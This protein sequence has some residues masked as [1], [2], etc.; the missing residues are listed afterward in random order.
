[1]KHVI[2]NV[3]RSIKSDGDNIKK[4]IDF[5][6]SERDWRADSSDGLRPIKSFRGKL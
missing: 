1:M 3:N 6:I 5:E 2:S 4:M